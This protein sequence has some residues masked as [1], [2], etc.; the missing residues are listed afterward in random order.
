MK[1]ATPTTLDGL[2]LTA[3][4]RDRLGKTI[5]AISRV[6]PGRSASKNLAQS[7][8]SFKMSVRRERGQWMDRPFFRIGNGKGPVV[9]P[10]WA[11][12]E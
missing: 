2:R 9:I 1:P 8:A 3:Q 10:Y 4:Q 6:N 11:S 7:I 5:D 12:D